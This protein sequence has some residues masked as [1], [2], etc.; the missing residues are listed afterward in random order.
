MLSSA[1]KLFISPSIV[2]S[3]PELPKMMVA[4]QIAP[5]H[6]FGLG[7]V[8]EERVRM[9]LRVFRRRDE[10][11]DQRHEPPAVALEIIGLRSAN[12][13]VRLRPRLDSSRPRQRSIKRNPFHHRAR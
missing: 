3:S 11:F 1:V 4:M 2:S 13:L 10:T 7:H 6:P 9:K 5:A 8:A 12:L